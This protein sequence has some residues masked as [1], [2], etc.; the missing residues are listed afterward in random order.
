MPFFLFVF[1]WSWSFWIVAAGLRLSV[2]TPQG[3]VLLLLGVL[4]PMVGGIGFAWFTRFDGSWKSY[5]A[6]FL[7]PRRITGGRW[8]ATFLFAPALMGLAIVGAVASGDT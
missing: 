4:G 8:A 1:G 6:R 2:Q 5:W 7:D 3:H